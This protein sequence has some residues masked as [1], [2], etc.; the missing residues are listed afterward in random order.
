[1]VLDGDDMLE[2]RGTAE[3]PCVLAGNRHRIRTGDAWTGSLRISHCTLK[4]LGGVAKRNQQGQVK[5]SGAP[6]LELKA[7][8]Q[9]AITIEHSVLDACSG[10]QLRTDDES[11]V[12]F[13]NN[14]VRENSVVAISKDIADSGDAFTASGS[15]Q[16]PKF[17]QGNFF[18]C[19]KV[20]I[21]GPNWLI[22][23]D[24]DSAAA[25]TEANLFI[26]LRI[27]INVDGAGTVVRG[28]YFHLLM[29]INEEYPY[30]SQI[31]V[32]TTGPAVVAERNVIRDGEWIVRFVE[33]E[34]R[35]NVISDIV[36]HNLCQNGSNGR[37]HHNLFVA[38]TSK[39]RHGSMSAAIAVIY[40]PKKPGEGIEIFNNV[41]D[42]GGR[43]DVPGIEVSPQAFVKSVRNNVFFN[44]AHS[45][46]YFRRPQGMIRASWNDE[47]KEEKPARI[48]YA[49]YNL[50]FN[51]GSVAR[52]NYLLSVADK[53]ERK[54]AGFGL[55]DVPRGGAIDEQADPKFKGPLREFPYSDDEVRARKV[56]V[57]QIL[58]R[59]REA[60][61]PAEGSPLIGAGDPSDRPGTNI[62]VW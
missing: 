30:W 32:F 14:T 12:V 8:K 39:H 34:F 41:F 61:T 56:T 5:G 3:K 25:D 29:P 47:S 20:M 55:N 58:A 43:M 24:G 18:P 4:E 59:Y 2:I 19:G 53:T 17:F 15:S 57:S 22:G 48:G 6:A 62:G 50:F 46:R 60:Y 7:T 52:R 1:L 27:G 9:A 37:I 16:Q 38:G 28:N 51:P 13:R 21:R 54:D 45:D 11:T 31:S 35:Y 10:M 44:F 26:G 42:G 23:G 33:G 40:P 49:D 36:D